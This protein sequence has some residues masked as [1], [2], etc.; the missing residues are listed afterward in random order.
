MPTP[1]DHRYRA[2]WVKSLG[3]QPPADFDPDA[4]EYGYK[5]F[6]HRQAAIDWAHGRDLWNEGKVFVEELFDDGCPD[7][8]RQVE[9]IYCFDDGS[10]ET[11]SRGWS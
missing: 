3:D 6:T 8:W 11:E 5:F 10:T 2:E 7:D 4:V 9:A 1:G